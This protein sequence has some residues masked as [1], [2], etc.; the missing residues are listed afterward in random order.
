[1]FDIA[2]INTDSLSYLATDPYEVHATEKKKKY[3]DACTQKRVSFTPLVFS[4]DGAPE[5]DAKHF[6]T[7]TANR[8][9]EKRKCTYAAAINWLRTRIS[10]V[11][12]RATSAG[13]RT[14]RIKW[15]TREITPTPHEP[16]PSIPPHD[17][18][19]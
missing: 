11:I 16:H 15:K 9:Q 6:I 13:V 12:I 5:K 19:T 17:I 2:V 3:H 18:H 10:L 4:V 7:H 8:L 1:M 14:T